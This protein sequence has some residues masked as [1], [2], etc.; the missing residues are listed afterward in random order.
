MNATAAISHAAATPLDAEPHRSLDQGCE[1]SDKFEDLCLQYR[2]DLYAAAMRMTRQ[3]DDAHDLVQETFLRAF[4]SWPHLRHRRNVRG[5]LFRILSNTF[6]NNYRKHRRHRRFT[7]ERPGEAVAAL[8][9]QTLPHAG[10]PEDALL[11]HALGDEVTAALATL[12]PDYRTVVEMADLEGVRYR[13]IAKKLCVPM[14]TVMSRLFRA[15]RK[16]EKSLRNFAAADYGIR[17][18]AC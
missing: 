13:D 6:I 3:P 14:G 8:Y 1:G 16:L 18:A 4:A 10:T 17:R 2:S 15:R 5:W 7:S 11:R 12:G 9:G